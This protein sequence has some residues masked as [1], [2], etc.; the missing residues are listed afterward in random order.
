[1][2]RHRAVNTRLLLSKNQHIRNS[3]SRVSTWSFEPDKVNQ[4]APQK[5][6]DPEQKRAEEGDRTSP[7]LMQ[8]KTDHKKSPEL[9][10]AEEDARDLT[11]AE[12][13]A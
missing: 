3:T 1:M 2:T 8:R 7:R 4:K 10:R 13:M 6:F 5:D 9:L 12:A 11:P